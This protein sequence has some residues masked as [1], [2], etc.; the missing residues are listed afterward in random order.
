VLEL[1]P[2]DDRAEFQA[3]LDLY[4]SGQVYRDERTR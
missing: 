2:A 1:I 4:E 3:R